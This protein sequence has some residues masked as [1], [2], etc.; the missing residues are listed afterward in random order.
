[1]Q[2]QFCACGRRHPM[3]AMLN[4]AGPCSTIESLSVAARLCQVLSVMRSGPE[5]RDRAHFL[6]GR[7]RPFVFSVFLFCLSAAPTPA[8]TN[9]GPARVTEIATL[10]APKPVGF[11]R[12]FTAC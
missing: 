10:L 2:E 6:I 4:R 12:P 9:I 8:V 3:P 1:M 11:R 5:P 7:A